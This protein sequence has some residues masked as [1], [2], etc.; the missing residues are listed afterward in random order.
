MDFGLVLQADPPPPGQ[1]V[2]CD[3]G[4]VGRNLLR[5]AFRHDD[6]RPRLNQL[7]GD[8]RKRVLFAIGKTVLEADVL[9][10]DPAIFL[11]IELSVPADDPAE[12]AADF[13]RLG[14]RDKA[15]F[16]LE[17]A[18]DEHLIPFYIKVQPAFDNI[19]SDPRYAD[20]LRRMGLPQ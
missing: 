19:R 20:L 13:A 15:F 10:F 2:A 1:I 7:G 17:K 3:R 8:P 14:E 9:P 18:Y 16:W 12:V 6:I 4:R 11:R 5:R